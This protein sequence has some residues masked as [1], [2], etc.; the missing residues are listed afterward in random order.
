[1]PTIHFSDSGVLPP[2]EYPATLRDMIYSEA[3]KS[4]GKP[5][6][7][8]EFALQDENTTLLWRTF[9]L[10]P[11]ATWSLKRSLVNLGEDPEY[12]SGNIDLDDFLDH[13]RSLVGNECTLVVSAGE[14]DGNPTAEI[15]KILP[16]GA[17][18]LP[19]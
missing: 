10:Q 1:M 18:A 14:Y 6:V 16:A 19:F 11:K 17:T 3:S 8:L 7:T 12:L 2:G 4:S 15:N 5:I 9:S 13:I